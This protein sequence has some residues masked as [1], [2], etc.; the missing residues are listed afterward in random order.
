MKKTEPT[1][2]IE[3]PCRK[4]HLKWAKT[5][6]QDCTKNAKAQLACKHTADK[7]SPQKIIAFCEEITKEKNYIH[8]F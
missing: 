8:Q 6:N 1:G 2:C 5:Q 4:R 7:E 3:V